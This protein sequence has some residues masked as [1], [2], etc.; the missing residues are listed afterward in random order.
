MKSCGLGFEEAHGVRN[1]Q[2]IRLEQVLRRHTRKLMTKAARLP[3]MHRQC[4]GHEEY[5]NGAIR[6]SVV[7]IMRAGVRMD[8]NVQNYDPKAR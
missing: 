7:T 4:I 3:T 6:L 2:L 1:H 5:S 8:I